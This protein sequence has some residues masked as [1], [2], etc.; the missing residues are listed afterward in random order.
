M[1]SRK[2]ECTLIMAYEADEAKVLPHINGNGQFVELK[3]TVGGH[4]VALEALVVRFTRSVDSEPSQSHNPVR[5]DSANVA[6]TTGL[7]PCIGGRE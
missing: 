2:S 3:P 4:D 5:A 1:F 6:G 7:S